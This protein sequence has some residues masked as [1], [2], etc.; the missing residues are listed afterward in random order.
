VLTEDG[1]AAAIVPQ[2]EAEP[3]GREMNFTIILTKTERALVEAAMEEAIEYWSVTDQ[4]GVRESKANQKRIAESRKVLA[5]I[6]AAPS[7]Y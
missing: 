7:R 6:L 3:R 1:E 4:T 2:D 5:K